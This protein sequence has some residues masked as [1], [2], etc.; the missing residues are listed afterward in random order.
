MNKKLLIF[1]FDGTIA[2]TLAVAVEIINEV[3]SDFGI[4]ALSI[5]EVTMLKQ[6]HIS[7]LMEMA[8]IS[9]LKLPLFIHRLRDAFSKRREEVAPIMG[10]SESIH[11][12][13]KAGF[14]LGILTSNSRDNVLFFLDKFDLQH[15]EF[16]IAPRSIFGK[17]GA[18]KDILKRERLDAR[19][20]VMIGDEIRDLKAANKAGI[21]AIAVSWGF[22]SIELL[23]EEEP[24]AILTNPQELTTLFHLTHV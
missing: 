3:G 8:G 1:D 11:S 17:A 6:K 7:E 9:W 13:H 2:D 15:F 20:V 12:L 10:M 21:D 18:I 23:K 16:V 14:R 22:N 4:P 24:S 19:D 5:A